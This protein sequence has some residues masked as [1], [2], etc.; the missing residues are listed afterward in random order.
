MKIRHLAAAVM[1]V[2]ASAATPAKASEVLNLSYSA[3]TGVQDPISLCYTDES[4]GMTAVDPSPNECRVEFPLTVPVG[5][6]VKQI[7]VLY[8][9]FPTGVTGFIQ[10]HLTSRKYGTPGAGAYVQEFDWSSSPSVPANTIA[11]GHL[12]D[13]S[14]GI[15]TAYPEAFVVQSNRVYEVTVIVHDSARLTGIRV[16]YD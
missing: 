5:R 9:T 6:T 13:Q 11:V 1:T 2:I 12:M 14:I 7:S 15:P 10:A 8:D 16:L 4:E 3:G